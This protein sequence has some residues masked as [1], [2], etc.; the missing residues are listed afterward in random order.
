MGG[1]GG[2]VD[3]ALFTRH[4]FISTG[5][6]TSNYNYGHRIIIIIRGWEIQYSISK[7]KVRRTRTDRRRRR[8]RD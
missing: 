7:G 3:F 6:R 8:R 1:K 4:T 2:Y 5:S